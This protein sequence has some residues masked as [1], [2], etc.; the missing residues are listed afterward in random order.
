MGE[1]GGY[2]QHFYHR[3]SGAVVQQN[4]ISVRSVHGAVIQVIERPK[5]VAGVAMTGW[6]LPGEN[7]VDLGVHP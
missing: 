4:S 6:A 3:F 2:A 7:S 5:R 1:V